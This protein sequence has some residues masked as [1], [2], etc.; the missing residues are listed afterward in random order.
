MLGTGTYPNADDISPADTGEAEVT[1]PLPFT[2]NF[3]NV[4]DAKTSGFTVRRVRVTGL[5][6]EPAP[7]TSPVKNKR[8]DGIDIN[9]VV[10]F[11]ILPFASTVTIGT[12]VED[13]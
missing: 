1:K 12:C 11:V 3:K 6:E 7:V 13:P 8:A 10:R 9:V 5:P 4:S 2:E